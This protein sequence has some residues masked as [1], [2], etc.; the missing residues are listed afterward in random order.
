MFQWC[1]KALGSVYN[2]REFQLKS[3]CR[4]TWV[5]MFLPLFDAHSVIRLHTHCQVEFIYLFYTV[6]F[7]TVEIC[8][9]AADNVNRGSVLSRAIKMRAFHG[10][11]NN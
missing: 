5:T 10:L 9:S 7:P 3:L 1:Q 8:S 11:L 6:L 4:Q 2:L